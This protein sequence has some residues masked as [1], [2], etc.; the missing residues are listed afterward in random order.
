MFDTYN[1]VFTI[2]LFFSGCS[3]GAYGSVLRYEI[4]IIE[5]MVKK[6]APSAPIT[7]IIPS[8][9]HSFRFFKKN[10]NPSD[11]SDDQN[12]RPGSVVDSVLVNNSYAEFFL[13]SHLAIQGTAK[14]P[15]YTIIYSTEKDASLDMFERWT[16]A[17]CYD[18]QIVTSPTSLPAP[19]YIANR[20]AERGRQIY[21]T[22]P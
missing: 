17:L 4:P 16:N 1:I 15:K 3:E 22:L 11:R 20:Y 19:V 7:V 2:Y 21:N 14:T 12:I 9:M 13:N 8:K 10:I 18:F 6:Y 5:A